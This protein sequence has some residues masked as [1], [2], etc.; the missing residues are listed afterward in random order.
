MEVSRQHDER[1]SE[2]SD[3]RVKFNISKDGQFVRL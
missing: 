2:T 1:I 3:L